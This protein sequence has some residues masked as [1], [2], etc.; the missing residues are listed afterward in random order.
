MTGWCHDFFVFRSFLTYWFICLGN[1]AIQGSRYC[2]WKSRTWVP[3]AACCEKPVFMVKNGKSSWL[4][5]FHHFVPFRHDLIIFHESSIQQSIPNSMKIV[6]IALDGS[7]CGDS[8]RNVIF[9]SR[10][11]QLFF[12]SPSLFVL[13]TCSHPFLYMHET[14]IN[15]AFD[16][17]CANTLEWA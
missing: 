4:L 14:S 5:T 1:P 2:F 11:V 7:R 10:W 9:L 3:L 16:L 13:S 6:G 12:I 17:H 15:V 8:F